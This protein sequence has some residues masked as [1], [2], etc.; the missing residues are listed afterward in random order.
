MG[1][2]H[3]DRAGETAISG[4]A[5]GS[6]GRRDRKAL[7][8]LGAGVL[9]YVLAVMQRTS[10]G[11]AGL[12]A[13]QRFSIDAGTLS[14]FVF[15]QVIVFVMAQV[16]AGL[17]VDRFGSRAM[18]VASAVLLTAGQLILAITSSLPLAVAARVL[19]GVG[20]AIVFS[21]VLAL[22]PR[23]F[24]APRVPVVSQLVT[25]LGQLGQVLSALPFAA[26]L[27]SA[28][29]TPAFLSAAAGSGL[30]AL[31]VLVA[32]RNAPDGNWTPA[33]AGS[34]RE[35]LG[36]VRDVWKRPHTRLGF[37]GHMGTQF[38]MMVFALLWGVP[39]LVT[40]QGMTAAG[41][42]GMITLFVVSSIVIGPIM[43][44]LTSRYPRRRSWLMLSVIGLQAATWTVV[45]IG[46]GPA[47]FWLLVVLVV[48]LATGGPGSMV[49][50]DIS[51]TANRGENLGL[52]QSMT[53]LGG[54]LATLIVL[55]TMGL[56]L[57]LLGGFTA[58]AFRNA[59]LVQYPVW[60]FAVVA[61]LVTRRKARRL[62]AAGGV[63]P[64]GPLREVVGAGSGS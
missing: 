26:L 4:A 9:A 16:P 31:V 14:F 45:L 39:Y 3:V 7:L 62:D 17:M 36:Q 24:A 8:V 47:P 61:V 35:L 58:E 29:W 64:A 48:V 40:G 38:S 10:V 22:V 28:G 56:V 50:I 44:T 20:D 11:A 46:S 5:S 52:A 37:F 32:V 59:W 12:D 13:A 49:G 2:R 27:H 55:A 41:A 60:A 30:V 51:R 23:W 34:A 63:V 43:G 54:F 21:G 25:I 18:L 53:N 6:A 1:N 19:V 33:P 15:L 57:N 42:G